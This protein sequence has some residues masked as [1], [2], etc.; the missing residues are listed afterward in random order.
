MRVSHIR[1]APADSPT[2]YRLALLL[3]SRI[4]LDAEHRD[5]DL[6]RLSRSDAR[7]LLRTVEARTGLV[8]RLVA[9]DARPEEDED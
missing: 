7:E 3:H 9:I 2:A 6:R 8:S 1:P 5:V 4:D